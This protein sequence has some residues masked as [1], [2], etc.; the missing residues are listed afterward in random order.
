VSGADPRDGSDAIRLIAGELTA[1][2]LPA[3]GMLCASLARRNIEFLRRVDAL[4][5]A[6]RT[7]AT[8]GIPLLHPWANRLDGTHFRAA[9][10]E[11]ALDPASPLLHF[12]ANVLP[13]HG[14]PWP[15]LRWR[16]VG[17]GPAFVT[18]CLDW[19]DASLL[20]VFPFPHRLEMTA[21]LGADGLTIGTTLVAGA[22]GAVPVCFGFHP[23]FGIPGAPRNEWRLV[24]PELR[25]L[26]LDARGLPTGAAVIEDPR[27]ERLGDRALDDAY[28]LVDAPAT[29]EIAAGAHRVSVQWL[30]GFGY[31][32]VYAPI[33]GDCVALEPMTAP[34]AALSSGRGLTVVG[35]GER[36]T[37]GFRIGVE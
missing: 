2:F 36:F 31:A 6:A 17:A 21:T 11:V 1:L 20:R 12:D 35:P 10:R 34:T 26:E 33:D 28:G 30:R 22:E 25:R 3:H 4:A 19:T 7:G 16:V 5:T 18:A 32:Q 23:Y 37:A 13:I 29:L 27:D 24:L 15:N 9:G 14:V 8:A